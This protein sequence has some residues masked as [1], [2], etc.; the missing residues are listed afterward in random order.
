M[1]F[2]FAILVLAQT[3]CIH[4]IG[5]GNHQECA[6]EGMILEGINVGSGTAH[7]RSSN[8]NTYDTVTN[9]RQ[10]QCAIPKTD[11]DKCALD[12]YE[13]SLAPLHRFNQGVPG[14]NILIGVGYCLYIIPGI[15]GLIYFNGQKDEALDDSD[16]MIKTSLK[17][18][19]QTPEPTP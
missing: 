12:V 15:V 5:V 2:F 4:R 11:A 14:K 17:S 8:F 16:Q 7:T 10:V 18:C 9:S 13:R 6:Q 1:R 19:E 3:A